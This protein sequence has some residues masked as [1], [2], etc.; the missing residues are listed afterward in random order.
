V[1]ELALGSLDAACTACRREINQYAPAAMAPNTRKMTKGFDLDLGFRFAAWGLLGTTP[2][3]Q[4]SNQNYRRIV[5]RL[6]NNCVFNKL[7][8]IREAPILFS[9]KAC[10]AGAIPLRV[11]LNLA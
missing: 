8:A 6:N 11:L 5:S 7:M 10:E 3:V 1:T 9:E 4:L 2:T